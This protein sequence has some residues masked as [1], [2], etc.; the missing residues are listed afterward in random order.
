LRLCVPGHGAAI[1][2]DEGALL[3]LASSAVWL[4]KHGDT[5]DYQLHAKF[6]I[7]KTSDAAWHGIIEVP[8]APIPLAK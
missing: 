5:S 7:A 8:P 4:F 3:D 6:T 2:K 1:P